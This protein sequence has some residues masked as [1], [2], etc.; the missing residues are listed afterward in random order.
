MMDF[1]CQIRG[2]GRLEDETDNHG[3]HFLFRAM[4]QMTKPITRLSQEHRYI[5]HRIDFLRARTLKTTTISMQAGSKEQKARMYQRDEQGTSSNTTND[6]PT[7]AEECAKNDNRETVGKKVVTPEKNPKNSMAAAARPRDKE[8]TTWSALPAS[9]A[10]EELQGTPEL[11]RLHNKEMR[12]TTWAVSV[13][14][15]A[16]MSA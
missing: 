3:I 12:R 1:P 16:G 5:N 10:D 2:V 8:I 11:S 9:D 6:N 13:R 7:D 4:T 15:R 14:K